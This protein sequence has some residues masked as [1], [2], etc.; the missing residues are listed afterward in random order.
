MQNI[1]KCIQILIEEF[2]REILEISVSRKKLLKCI[3]RTKYKG[4]QWIKLVE[5]KEQW[6][7]N[8]RSQP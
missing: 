5:D 3:Y 1:G 7:A 4:A 6:M 2:K 8:K